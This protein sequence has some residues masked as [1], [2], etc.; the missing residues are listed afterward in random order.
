M[1]RQND[2]IT[3]YHKID[4]EGNHCYYFYDGNK[5]IE[6]DWG[7]TGLIP[8]IKRQKRLCNITSLRGTKIDGYDKKQKCRKSSCEHSIYW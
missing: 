1:L 5:K 4:D 2:R 7:E 8:K 6:L 3:V